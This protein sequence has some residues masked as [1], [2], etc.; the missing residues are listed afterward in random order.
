MKARKRQIKE[1][2]LKDSEYPALL[3]HISGPPKSIFVIGNEKI[4]NQKAITV[5]GSRKMT[6]YGRQV[7]EKLVKDLVDHGLVIVSGLA[8]G[9][10]GMAHRVCLQNEG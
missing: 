8:R 3:K 4:L 7:T 2:F 6:G 1:T 9:I 10:D 5:I